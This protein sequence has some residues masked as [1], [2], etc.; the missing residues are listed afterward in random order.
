MDS[1]EGREIFE[2]IKKG[3]E[4]A[5]EVMFFAFYKSLCNYAFRF[6]DEIETAEEVTQDIFVKLWEKRSTIEI[7]SSLKNYLFR[8]VKNQCLNILQHN[9]IKKKYSEK[10]I[11]I[12]N[13]AIDSTQYFLEPE[14]AN[15]IEKAISLMPEKRKEVFRLS[16]EEGLKY[17][18]IAEKLNIS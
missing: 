1:L 15:K 8:S 6:V 3:D 4:H 16:R 11:E 12:S 7:E 18:E 9:K 13:Q 10:L 17:K 14:L 2:K 5:F